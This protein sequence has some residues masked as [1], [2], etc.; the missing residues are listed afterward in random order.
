MM[1]EKQKQAIIELRI[2]G[3]GYGTIAKRMNMKLDTVKSFCRRHNMSNKDKLRAEVKDVTKCKNCGGE[4]LQHPKRKRKLF[5]CDKCRSAWWASHP[6]MVNRKAYYDITCLN[7]G[8]I[9]TA[10][11]DSHRKYCCHECYIEHRFGNKESEE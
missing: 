1:T 3:M 8:K 4:V 6:Y 7:C 2:D 9:F 11:G 10:Y 5:C